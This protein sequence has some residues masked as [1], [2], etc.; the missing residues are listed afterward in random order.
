MLTPRPTAPRYSGLFVP[1]YSAILNP[2]GTPGSE[3]GPCASCEHF[4]CRTARERGSRYRCVY[5]RM[6]V[7]FT[8]PHELVRVGEYAHVRCRVEHRRAVG[9]D[10]F[11]RE[12]FAEL[13]RH[14]LAHRAEAMADAIIAAGFAPRRGNMFTAGPRRAEYD[15]VGNCTTCGAPSGECVAY[16]IHEDAWA[17]ARPA[18][19]SE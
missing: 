8:E 14:G 13:Q 7:G 9:V 11:E 2:I 3:S 5:C 15:L 17:A 10:A 1:T 12:L 18:K 19:P 6:S 4:L 16:H